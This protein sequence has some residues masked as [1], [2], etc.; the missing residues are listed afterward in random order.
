MKQFIILILITNSIFALEI[1]ESLR[2][3]GYLNSTALVT[4]EENRDSFEINGGIQGRYQVT[5]NISFT[6]HIYFDEANGFILFVF[7]LGGDS[8]YFCAA[9]PL[10]TFDSV[11]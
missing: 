11:H 1:N 5:E 3:D 4:D 10:V 2:L 7:S 9:T 8:V 6:G